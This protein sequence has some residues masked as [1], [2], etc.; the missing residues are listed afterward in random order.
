ME[1]KA[2]KTALRF[3]D[4]NGITKDDV[5][6][7]EMNEAFA[8]QCLANNKILQ[9][10]LEKINIC[11]GGVALG[12]PI[13]AS[14]ARVLTTLIHQMIRTGAKRGITSLC[15]GGG[16]AVNMLIEMD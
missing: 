2:T 5:D 13:G 4:R 9:I 16:N 10:P 1:P 6:L 3:F 11:G 15:L 7:F 14:G 12:H 8:A